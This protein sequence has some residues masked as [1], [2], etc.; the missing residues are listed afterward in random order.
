MCTK[1][2]PN[3][4]NIFTGIFEE[5][6]IYVLINNTKSLNL[7]FIDNIFLLWTRTFKETNKT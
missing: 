1:C 2:A 6:Y 3:Y 5:K 4:T 7:R